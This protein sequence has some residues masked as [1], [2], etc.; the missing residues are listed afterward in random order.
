M[1]IARATLGLAAS[2]A[3]LWR[4]ERLT[5]E[6]TMNQQDRGYL[7]DEDCLR[8]PRCRHHAIVLDA[9]KAKPSVSAKE[10]PA[11][12]ASVRDGRIAMRSGRKK[13]SGGVE[14]KK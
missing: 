6:R 2:D 4:D 10:R 12:T 1:C 3:M 11:L 7:K 8:L 14:Q 13:A 5:T 9:I